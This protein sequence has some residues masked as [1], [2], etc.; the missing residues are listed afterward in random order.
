VD[1]TYSAPDP[2]VAQHVLNQVVDIFKSASAEDAQQAVHTTAAEFLESQLKVNDFRSW[3]TRQAVNGVSPA[4]RR[5]RVAE[6][7]GA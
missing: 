5:L 4:R 6:A 7:V 1:V 3:P 2:Y